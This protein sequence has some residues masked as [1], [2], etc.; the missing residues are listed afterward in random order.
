MEEHQLGK[1]E[2]AGSIPVSGFTL[3][4]YMN[5]SE[6]GRLGGIKTGTI[7]KEKAFKKYYQNPI[8]CNFCGK[9]IDIPVG[10]RPSSITRKKFCNH[11]C[12]AKK[13]NLGI[14]HNKRK[15]KLCK[16]CGNQ[17]DRPGRWYCS[18]CD[19]EGK[20]LHKPKFNDLKTDQSRRN[21]FLEEHEHKCSI[22]GLIEWMEKEIPLILDHIDGNSDH[23]NE[24]NLR[25][26]CG[27]CDMQL[28][29]YKGRNKGMGRFSRRERYK[30]GKSF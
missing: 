6:A 22:C 26:V 15:I 29:T 27:N 12:A 24:T 19:S 28:P 18:K 17:I 30:Q 7:L 20:N 4:R 16:G 5:P 14:I 9:V 10:S 2:V 25:L 13:N 21:R 1:L 23:N 11:S 3:R 8:I